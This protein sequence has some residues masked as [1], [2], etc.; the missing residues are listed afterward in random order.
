M[1]DVSAPP[2]RPCTPFWATTKTPPQRPWCGRTG[3]RRCAE[4]AGAC[5]SRSCAHADTHLPLHAP[6][7]YRCLRWMSGPRSIPIASAWCTRS[8]ENLRV[9]LGEVSGLGWCVNEHGYGQWV[10]CLCAHTL[11]APPDR[12]Q[13]HPGVAAVAVLTGN[14]SRFDLSPKPR[15]VAL[16]RHICART[17][18]QETMPSPSDDCK[19]FVCGS[20]AVCC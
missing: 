15:T 8:R 7:T 13:T 3:G 10:C 18:R 12:P 19:I 14:S 2:A 11:V 4:R 16:A 9:R 17:P 1:C 5:V 20:V 6:R